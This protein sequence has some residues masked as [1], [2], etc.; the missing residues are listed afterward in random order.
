[1]RFRLQLAA[2]AR[3]AIERACRAAWP[4]EVVALLGGNGGDVGPWRVDAVEVLADARTSGDAFDVDAVA[5]AR[6]EH[7]LRE[8]GRRFVGFVHSHPG[9]AAAPSV[10][11]RQQLWSD[12][13]QMIAAT[14]GDGVT[15]RAF[16]LRGERVEPLPIDDVPAAEAATP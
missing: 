3:A 7:A 5:F 4:R 12:C 6:G 2:T 11:D 8:R 16:R 13:V 15:L 10:R 1:M 9:G 14:D